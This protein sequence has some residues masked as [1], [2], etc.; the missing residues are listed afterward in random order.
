MAEA[1]S[2]LNLLQN[3]TT[4]LSRAL[5]KLLPWPRLQIKMEPSFLQ[6]QVSVYK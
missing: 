4:L 3:V 6:E 5:L 1:D 2:H